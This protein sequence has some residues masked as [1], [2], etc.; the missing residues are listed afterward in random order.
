M[1]ELRLTAS[2]R[3]IR[4]AAEDVS[5]PELPRST[6]RVGERRAMLLAEE[7]VIDPRV[8]Y[9]GDDAFER[10]TAWR[11][12]ADGVVVAQLCVRMRPSVGGALR[13]SGRWEELAVGFTPFAGGLHRRRGAVEPDGVAA[14]GNGV[15]ELSYGERGRPLPAE[16]AWAFLPTEVRD[17]AERLVPEPHVVSGSLR[18]VTY[19]DGFV[20]SQSIVALR[21]SA[22][23]A[24]LVLADRSPAGS[25]DGANTER[26]ERMVRTPWVVEQFG[27]DLDAASAGVSP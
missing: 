26:R 13:S 25:P 4:L 27:A 7:V 16:L 19:R 2:D 22:H 1:N 23:R 10:A 24:L 14:S 9:D 8:W 11:F 3:R 15:A 17:T 21:M 6:R 12:F 20:R 18:Q 5:W